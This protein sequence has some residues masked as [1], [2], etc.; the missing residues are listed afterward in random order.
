MAAIMLLPGFGGSYSSSVITS[1]TAGTVGSDTLDCSRC[2]Q[3]AIVLGTSAGA[4]GQGTIQIEQSFTG[5]TGPYIIIG[6]VITISSN[7][8]S[9]LLDVTDGPFGLVRFKSTLVAGTTNV[10]IVGFPI[11]RMF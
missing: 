9:A 8:T 11:Q 7:G 6:T 1:L 4:N 2:A 5:P 3:L 10:N